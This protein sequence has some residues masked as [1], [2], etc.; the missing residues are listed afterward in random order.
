MFAGLGLASEVAE[1]ALGVAAED[2]D[3]EEDS[4]YGEEGCGADVA[5]EYAGDC[6]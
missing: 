3:G 6:Y 4:G 5:D 2:G 1:C